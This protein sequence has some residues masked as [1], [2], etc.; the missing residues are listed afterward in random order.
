MLLCNWLSETGHSGLGAFFWV[1]LDSERV[2]GWYPHSPMDYLQPDSHVGSSIFLSVWHLNHIEF[3]ADRHI[4]VPIGNMPARYPGQIIVDDGTGLSKGSAIA[5]SAY[6]HSA[7]EVEAIVNLKTMHTK[8]LQPQLDAILAGIPCST[9]IQ[10]LWAH[11]KNR[12]Y[13]SE[14]ALYQ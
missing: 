14:A 3:P 11:T 6:V 2:A 9:L 1:H 7:N 8:F 4:H 13:A 12:N 5:S 10:Y